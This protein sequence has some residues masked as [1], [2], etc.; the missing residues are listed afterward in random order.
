MKQREISTTSKIMSCI[1][2][3]DTKPEKLLSQTMWKAGLNEYTNGL[4]RQ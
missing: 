3:K 1:K 4:I 2:S